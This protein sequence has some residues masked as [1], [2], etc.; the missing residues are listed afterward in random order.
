MAEYFADDAAK[1]DCLKGQISQTETLLLDT[2]NS[3]ED[4]IRTALARDDNPEMYDKKKFI[5]VII[6]G[7]YG[8]ETRAQLTKMQKMLFYEDSYKRQ[9]RKLAKKSN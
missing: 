8:A 1:I 6:Q 9:L 7:N 4:G 2:F 3:L 5:G